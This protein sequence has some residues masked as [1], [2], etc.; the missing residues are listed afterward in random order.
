MKIFLLTHEREL[1]R[2]TNTGV[3]ALM[4]SNHIVERVLWNRVNSDQ[5]L[6]TLIALIENN[7]ALLLYSQQKPDDEELGAEE[8]ESLPIEQSASLIKA[9]ENI[10]IIDATWQESKKIF[11]Q[12]VYLKNAQ[13]FTLKT[14][15]DSVYKLRA[16]QPK[17]GLCTIEC[18]IEILKIK[19]HQKLASELSL[20]FEQ[21]NR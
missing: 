5:D 1:N 10:I 15:N 21:F 2:G 4:H 3:I 20:K 7:Q 9:F 19:G 16:N 6:L 12:S 11:N 14:T 13:H 17:G 8:S 18:I